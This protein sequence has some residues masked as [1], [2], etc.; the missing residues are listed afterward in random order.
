MALQLENLTID[1]L[2]LFKG[3][4]L[5]CCELEFLFFV[6]LDYLFTAELGA[7]QLFSVASLTTC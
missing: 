7:R 1:S 4:E 6:G 3:K 2:Q 5:N